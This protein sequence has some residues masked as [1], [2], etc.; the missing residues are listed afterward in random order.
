[1]AKRKKTATVQLKLRI[2]EELRQR[3]ERQARGREVSLNNEMVR[4]LENSFES[5]TTDLLVRVL[6][7]SPSNSKLLGVIASVLQVAEA[8]L[9]KKTRTEP[10]SQP[11]RSRRL[12]RLISAT[13]NSLMTIF[14]TLRTGR[15]P[16]VLRSIAFLSTGD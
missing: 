12:S 15:A 6:T 3:L 5:G 7:G 8:L 9:T 16:T 10:Q 13:E 4:R 14:Q 2:R 11:R 1:M